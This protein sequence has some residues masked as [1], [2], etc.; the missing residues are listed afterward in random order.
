MIDVL[1]IG[2]GPAG[3][4]AGIYTA[5]AGLS[6]VLL[7][8]LVPG[9]QLASIDKLENYPGFADGI[10]GFDAALALRS[11]AERFG[12]RIV[13]DKA[14]GIQV[15]AGADDLVGS[16]LK[17][18]N[19]VGGPNAGAGADGAVGAG[20]TACE[21][22]GVGG[23]G[24]GGDVLAGVSNPADAAAPF[25]VKGAQGTYEA[26]SII[27]ATGAKPV[28]LPVDGAEALVG[29]GVS[30][31]ATCDGNFFRGKAVAVVGGGDS[32]CADA[33]Y[34]SR[35]ASEV[36]LIHRRDVLRANPWYAQQLEQLPNLTI[37]WDTVVTGIDQTEGRLS[38]LELE[39]VKSHEASSLP[40]EGL[41]VAIGTRPETGWLEGTVALDA[42][43]YI[44]A[45]QGGATSQPGIFAAGDV[46][47]TPLRQVVTAVA[48][49]ALAAESAA[50]FLAAQ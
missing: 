3:L 18:V 22:G 43:G 14:V 6:V 33:V 35:V 29:K 7:E 40:V 47:T 39:N 11:Q 20:S 19:A 21:G 50:A 44:V 34:L 16:V 15:G 27:V 23:A 42:N 1:I 49:G 10:N 30:Y 24:I 32:A 4:S 26:R 5:R 13:S 41:F 45:Q 2:A 46:R 17:V 31:C 48:D 12:A 38:G 37:H 25:A 8:E 9:G 28:P 36:H